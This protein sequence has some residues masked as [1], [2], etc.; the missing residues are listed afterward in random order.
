MTTTLDKAGRVGDNIE[1]EQEMPKV[2][3]SQRSIESAM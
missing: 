1:L 3:C 2:F